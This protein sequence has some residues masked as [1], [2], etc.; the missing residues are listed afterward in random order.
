MSDGTEVKG[1]WNEGSS[2]QLGEEWQYIDEPV[3]CIRDTRGLQDLEPEGTERTE[4]TV[5]QLDKR[6][7]KERSE[8]INQA[9][10]KGE[11]QWCEY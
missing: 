2:T 4:K 11:N 9:V 1:P 10:P 8:E 6:L 3:Q 5:E 7:R